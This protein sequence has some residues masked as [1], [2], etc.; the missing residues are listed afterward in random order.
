MNHCR[1]SDN[2]I[3]REKNEM[4]YSLT[5]HLE[6]LISKSEENLNHCQSS[7]T[8]TKQKKRLLINK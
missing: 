8:L 6:M 2:H 5:F 1:Y 4:T 7:L 3:H